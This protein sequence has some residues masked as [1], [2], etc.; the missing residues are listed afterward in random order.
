M[1]FFQNRFFGIFAVLAFVL[2]IYGFFSFYSPELYGNDSFYH[3]KLA[4][5]ML[6]DGLVPKEFPW[7]QF[8]PLNRNF[9]DKHFLFHLYLIPFTLFEDLAFGLKLANLILLSLVFLFFYFLL[10]ENKINHAELWVIVFALGSESFIYRLL[11]GRAIT[12]GVLL[13]LIGFYLMQKK[14]Y[15]G[16]AAVSFIFVW[17]YAAF[18]AIALLALSYSFGIYLTKKELNGKIFAFC[19]LGIILGMVINPFFPD[20]I[21]LGISS[22]LRAA[23]LREP[24]MSIGEW[25]SFS[26]WSF[27]ISSLPIIFLLLLLFYFIAFKK[28]ELTAKSRELFLPLLLFLLM[29]VKSI[30][31]ID[32]FVPVA[33]LFSA[34]SFNELTKEIKPKKIAALALITALF[35][36]MTA[37][38]TINSL[39]PERSSFRE[40]S[41]WLEKN[42]PE[43]S[44]V[45]LWQY[46]DFPMLFYHNTHNYYTEG[47][48]S[49]YLKDFNAEL[50]EVKKQIVQENR[51]ELIKPNFNSNYVFIEKNAGL[52]EKINSLKKSGEVKEIHEWKDCVVIELKQKNSN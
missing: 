37:F 14:N 43:K 5:I 28:S 29:A 48:D 46:D 22:D 2:L 40:C 34:F 50:F 18:P 38:S 35:I 32:F 20:N 4:K 44:V 41:E 30:R 31:V 23:T 36:G 1:N 24:G 51:L 39:D 52:K 15:L 7:M 47:L 26:S 45:F 10:K 42:T 21:I 25:N 13:F 16:I 27:L 33:V 17:S 49:Y 6:D 9:V 3:I 11:L 8:T 12:L 19:L